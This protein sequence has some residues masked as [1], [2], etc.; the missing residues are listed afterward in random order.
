MGEE[1]LWSK[2]GWHAKFGRS[3]DANDIGFGHTPRD[4]ADFKSPA[5]ETLLGYHLAVLERSRRY[6]SSP[7]S[8]DL[9]EE[10]K[11][12]PFPPPMVGLRRIS[13]V[14]S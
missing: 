11:E 2:D 6:I 5:A 8:A 14:I 7:T 13:M 3:S 10:L 1:Q 9:D 4:L 12:P